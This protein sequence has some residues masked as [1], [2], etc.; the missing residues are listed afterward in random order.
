LEALLDLAALMGL[1]NGLEF[2]V[3]GLAGLDR[4][5]ERGFQGREPART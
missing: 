3:A 4:G 5:R 2:A 1:L